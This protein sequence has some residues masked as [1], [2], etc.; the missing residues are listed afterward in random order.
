[1]SW[2]D[3]PARCGDPECLLPQPSAE[4]EMDGDLLVYACPCGYEFPAGRV[5]QDEGTCAAGL[6]RPVPAAPQPV[7]LGTIG[8]RPS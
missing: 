4:P 3:E 7:F 6:Q 2:V 8:R 1:V 5:G